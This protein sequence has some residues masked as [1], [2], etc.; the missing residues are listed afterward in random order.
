MY[1]MSTIKG[2]NIHYTYPCGKRALKGVSI[3]AEKGELIAI[4]GKNGSGKSTLARHLDALIPLQKGILNIAGYNAADKDNIWKIRRCT[5][6]VFQNPDNQFV[7]SLLEEDVAFGCENHGI[8]EEETEKRVRRALE[9]TGLTDKRK[10]APYS[11]SG[12][13]KQRAAL[14]GV[15]AMD[16]DI[17]IFDEALSM[18]DASGRKE[19]LS[20]IHTLKQDKTIILITHYAEE[21]VDADKVMV[22]KDGKLLKEG[23]PEDILTDLELLDE[24]YLKAPKCVCIA[25]KLRDRGLAIPKSVLT[26]QALQEALECL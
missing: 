26:P 12:G 21:A 16:P 22:M 2:N 4:L 1:P 23:K 15:L 14:A 8:E 13:E 9:L 25:E 24:A 18:L 10:R 5:G 6:I 20:L 3:R 17:I 11:L 7:S 19:M